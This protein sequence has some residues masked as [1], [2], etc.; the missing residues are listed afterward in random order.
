MHRFSY[1]RPGSLEEAGKA[2]AEYAG[3]AVVLAA[4]TDI[5]PQIK[6]GVLKPDALVS[7]NGIE[8]LRAIKK[9]GAAS[10]FIG[11]A[12]RLIDL[13]DSSLIRS[14]IPVI[15]RTAAMMGS[16][17]VRN[18]ATAGGN[19][20]NASP[21]ADLATCLLALGAEAVIRGASGEKR[22]PLEEFFTGPGSTVI[23]DEEILSG[24]SVPDAGP[25]HFSTYLKLGARATLNLAIVGV[26]LCAAPNGNS[27]FS[28]IRISLG[29]VAPTPIRSRKAEEVILSEGLS[30]RA[31]EEASR[32]AAEESRPIDDQRASKEYRKAMVS[33]LVQRALRELRRKHEG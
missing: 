10:L 5:F 8:S 14:S 9:E 29:A 30:D 28:S 18:R 12:A 31:I 27:G 25:A 32:L 20:C 1:Y 6:K 24:V 11:A 4:G 33:C 21:S 7:I 19:L 17:Q 13:A 16:P 23:K 2:L 26:G 22:V 15:G 3:R